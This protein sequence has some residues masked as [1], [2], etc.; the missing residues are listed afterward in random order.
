MP[1]V[2]ERYIGTHWETIGSYTEQ[3]AAEGAYKGFHQQHPEWTL[4]LVE[5]LKSAMGKKR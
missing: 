5:V 1:Y 2:I 3:M 4:R